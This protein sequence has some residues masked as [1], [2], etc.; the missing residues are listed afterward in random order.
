M[1]IVNFFIFIQFMNG[2]CTVY[3]KYDSIIALF[4]T[5]NYPIKEDW[6]CHISG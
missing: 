5:T 2:R 6:F 3:L 4:H 1:L